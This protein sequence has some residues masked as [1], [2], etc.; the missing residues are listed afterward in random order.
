MRRSDVAGGGEGRTTAV[1]SGTAGASTTR[2]SDTVERGAGR[3]TAVAGAR[4]GGDTTGAGRR[5]SDRRR[6]R[7]VTTTTVVVSGGGC[8][9]PIAGSSTAV[10]WYFYPHRFVTTPNYEIW[11]NKPPTAR[12]TTSPS[13]MKFKATHR[14][15]GSPSGTRLQENVD[16]DLD[17][18]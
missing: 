8:G 18:K 16:C 1:A 6:R 9:V 7:R 17:R 10:G 12:L 13:P 2:K 14:S 5:R 11:A 15:H 4:G 3:K